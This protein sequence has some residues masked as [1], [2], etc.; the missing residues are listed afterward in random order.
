MFAFKASLT[1]IE[2]S[3]EPRK[4]AAKLQLIKLHAFL[5]HADKAYP[6]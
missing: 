6:H 3:Q 4:V 2:T 1:L 5:L